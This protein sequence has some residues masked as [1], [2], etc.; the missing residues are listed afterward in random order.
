[1]EIEALAAHRA[2]VFG[3]EVGISEVV[4]EGDC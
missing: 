3:L 2:L 4:L 1:M